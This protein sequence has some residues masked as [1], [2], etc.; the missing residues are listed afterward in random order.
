MASISS[1]TTTATP[2]CA[3]A[4][5]DGRRKADFHASVWGDFFITHVFSD[6]ETVNGWIAGIEALKK[7]VKAMLMTSTPTLREKLH[8]I[9]VVERLGIGYHFEA[10]IEELLQ[11]VHDGTILEEAVGFAGGQL[12]NYSKTLLLQV[13]DAGGDNLVSKRIDH[14]LERPLRKGA[15]RHEQLFFITAY[16]QDKGHSQILLKLAK[17]SWNHVQSIYQQEI[18]A[19]S[20][21]WVELDFVT[22]L[23][24]SRDRLVEIYFWAIGSMW[25]PKL[26]L[27][28]YFITKITILISVTDDMYDAH[29]QL[30]ELELFTS[31]VERWDTSMKDLPEYMRIC[32]EAIIDAV[33]EIA[34]I[35]SAEGRHYCEGY[36]K[37]A[38]KYLV[39][40]YIEQA[41]WFVV[42]KVPTVE[43][44]RRV[45]IH[46]SAYPPLACAALCGLGEKAPK[47]AF[48]WLLS[49][50]KIFVAVSD[51]CRLM[52]DVVS[53]QFEQKRGH[54]PSVV[55]CFM[56]QYEVP[57]NK[58]VEAVNKM[59][60]DDWKDINKECL[61]DQPSF[62]SKE[63]VSMLVGFAKVMEVLYTD[64]DSYTFSDTTTK[65][66]VT[67]LLVTPMII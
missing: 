51:H 63:I 40:S 41:R 5:D 4:A 3:L 8:L 44:Y 43:E 37:E 33:G 52:D 49:N 59:V 13:A 50:S 16:E 34:T 56:K 31:T 46:S 38:E 45:G 7:E 62:V 47:E 19:I 35:T 60:E 11:Q 24:F 55:E 25:E 12:R 67:A 42:G 10:E 39:R 64:Y 2:T 58:A 61:I 65:D 15:D 30:D 14:V 21:W 20:Q 1:N 18:R 54:E 26:A 17:L 66:M 36:M 9:D 32:Y 6:Q 27:S 48:D 22:R 53:H 28:R 23:K 57:R 29:G